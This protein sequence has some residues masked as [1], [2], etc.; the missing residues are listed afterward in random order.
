MTGEAGTERAPSLA[1]AGD[2][3]LVHDEDGLR[4]ITL[5]RPAKRNA[6][7][8][9]MYAELADALAGATENPDIR[10]VLLT[11]SGGSFTAGN[12]L[13]DMAANPPT[14]DDAPPLR[15]LAALHALRPVLVAEVDGPAIGVGTTVLPHCDLAYASARAVFRLP[16][17]DLGL[18]P[19]AASTLLLPR[20]VGARKAA[21]LM[22]F[23]EPFAA[24][25]ALG[26]GLLN[27][28]AP[29]AEALREMV[30]GRVAA[31]TGKPPAALAATKRLLRD[32]QA[33]TVSE[34]LELDRKVFQS[35]LRGVKP[36]DARPWRAP[37]NK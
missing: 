30:S 22:L 27:A 23:G 34:R 26:M 9:A 29:D 31:L 3:V 37:F 35:L 7:T 21:E 25:E 28:V 36:P 6:I 14:G 11:G 2:T 15:F 13:K 4:T 24:A 32:E 12:D 1:P 5:N 18:V 8:M 17:V 10:V 33:G 20:L 16:F 19:E